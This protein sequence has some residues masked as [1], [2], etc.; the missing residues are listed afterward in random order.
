MAKDKREY[1]LTPEDRDWIINNK[2]AVFDRKQVNKILNQSVNQS[3]KVLGAILF[4][5]HSGKL[6][7]LQCCVN[8]AN[9][10]VKK[11]LNSA[12]VKDERT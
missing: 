12:M 1:G 8:L 3:D 6:D 11:L 2:F 7:D 9:Q 10:D 4:L 5:A